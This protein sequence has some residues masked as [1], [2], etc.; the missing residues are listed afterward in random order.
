[1]I[2]SKTLQ[3]NNN[4]RK[5]IATQPPPPAFL[6][7]KPALRVVA[8]SLLLG[9]DSGASFRWGLELWALDLPWN[10]A[11]RDGVVDIRSCY[12]HDFQWHNIIYLIIR[13]D[14]NM[15]LVFH[16]QIRF[17]YNKIIQVRNW[18]HIQLFFLR[19]TKTTSTLIIN[20]HLCHA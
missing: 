4:N 11:Q 9:I 12:E 2:P 3:D 6:Q 10:E 1:M 14:P 16:V 20:C 19:Y 5:T 7:A 15:I 8:S 13:S 18:Y 17:E